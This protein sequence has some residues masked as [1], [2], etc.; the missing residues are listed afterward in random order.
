MRHER[1]FQRLAHVN[2]GTRAAGTPGHAASADYV[3]G[4]LREAGYQVTLQPFEFP[5]FDETAPP[6]LS[7]V[8]PEP[9]R[10]ATPADFQTMT[11]SGSG[12]VEGTVHPVDL[13]LADPASS[14]S[15]CEASDFAGFPAG[16]IALIQRGA[17]TFE[18]KAANAQ[19]AGAT[20]VIVMNQGNGPD[21]LG[22]FSGT[23]G[24]PFTLPVVGASFAVGQDLAAPAG[25]VARVVTSTVNEPRI[26]N[27]VIAETRQGRSDNVV[28]LGAHLDSVPEGPGI[29]DNG[30]GSAALLELALQMHRIKPKN[31]VRFAWWSAEE[32]GLLG[33]EY[34]VSQLDFERQLD[35]AMYLNFDMIASPNYVRGIYDGDDSDQVGSGPGPVGSASIEKLFEQHSA[36]KGLPFEGTDFTGRSD[37]GPFIAVGIPAGGL[38]TGAEGIKTAEQAGRYGGT[39]GTAFDPCYHQS[40]DTL[41]NLNTTVFDTNADAVA[42]A[43]GVYA[44]DTSSVNG[45]VSRAELRRARRS[46]A[47]LSAAH[48]ATADARRYEAVR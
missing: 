41:L 3:A 29:N 16:S 48:P 6:A 30:S 37:Y 17:C 12:T 11:Y 14:T 4:K 40:C 23:L 20:A 2:D 34:Y 5:F 13:V 43:T 45:E 27:N 26:T 31:K 32:L 19:A 25:T 15:G 8:S 10:Y 9:T 42:H 33:S 44:F 35:I 38:F 22:S 47:A 36:A 39:A 28:M 18:T 1:A 7:Q 46:A 21:R 24:R